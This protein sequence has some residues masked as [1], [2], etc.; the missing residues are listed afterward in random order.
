MKAQKLKIIR[1]EFIKRYTQLF[2]S[3]SKK[4]QINKLWI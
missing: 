4:T 1:T 3:K 2:L